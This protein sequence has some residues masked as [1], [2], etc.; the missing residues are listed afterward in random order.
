VTGGMYV[1]FVSEREGRARDAYGANYERLVEIKNR[2]NP[3]NL[4]R[5]N[6]NIK[7]TV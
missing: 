7:S 1:N 3:T 6:Q 2:Y 4:F 5:M